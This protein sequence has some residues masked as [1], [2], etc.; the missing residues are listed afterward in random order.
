M[1]GGI[2]HSRT[3]ET[4]V[5]RQIFLSVGKDTAPPGF[6][7][8]EPERKTEIHVKPFRA[9]R[10]SVSIRKEPQGVDQTRVQFRSLA[11]LGER[12]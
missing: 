2:V 9:K 3:L 10:F 7:R 4:M 12:W 6:L 5:A 1:H 11:E 8:E